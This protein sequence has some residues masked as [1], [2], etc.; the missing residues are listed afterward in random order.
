[1]LRTLLLASLLI[2]VLA[3]AGAVEPTPQELDSLVNLYDGLHRHPELSFHE[4]ETAGTLIAELRPLGFD[5]TAPIGGTGFAAILRNG[6]GPT[7]MIRTD[8]DGLPVVEQTGRADASTVRT[9]D[10]SGTEVGV[11]HACGHDVHM[12]SFIGTARALTNAKDQWSGTLL[13]IGQPAEERGAGA[14]AML[15]DGLFS[16]IAKPD[17]AVALHSSASLPTGTI[18]YTSGYAFANVDSVDITIRG[19]G[20]HGAYPHTTKDPVVIAAYVVTALQTIV[21][22]ETN[23][24]ESVVVTVGSIHG[25]T[26]HN[27]ISDEVKLQLT[28]RSYS[29]ESRRQTLD[30]IRRITLATAEAFGVPA[31]KRPSVEFSELEYTPSVYNDPELTARLEKAWTAALGAESV[32]AVPP[33]MAGE[34]F[35]RYGRTDDDIP[36]VIFWLGTVAPQRISS[37][38]ALPSLHSPYFSP[39]PRG[40]IRTG[41][42]AMTTAVLELLGQ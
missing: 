16:K 2:T 4:S 32:N 12:A 8:L 21:S 29:D 26:K 42:D 35:S 41:V 30:S 34:D 24:L 6:E 19:V 33:V 14:N 20:G 13:L 27:I 11:M 22:R 18:G 37:G 7:V 31:D 15:A 5:I 40:S 39:E 1:M 38:E 36:T 10:D 25:G 3:P 28:V 23:P 17:Y 9:T